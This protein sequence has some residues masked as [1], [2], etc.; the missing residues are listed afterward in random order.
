MELAEV[1]ELAAY[2]FIRA[3]SSVLYANGS[4]RVGLN[5]GISLNL[6]RKAVRAFETN[7]ATMVTSAIE[8]GPNFGT[9]PVEPG[10]PVF[11]HS[12]LIADCRALPGFTK[13]VE[14]GSAIKP[15]HPREF[16]ECEGFRFISSPIF[17]PFLAAGAAYSGTGMLSAGSANCDVYPVIIMAEGAWGHVSLKGY[18]Y[19]GIKP[20]IISSQDINHANPTGSFGYVGANFWYGGVRLN[21]NHMLRI[22]CCASDLA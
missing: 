14:Y 10:Y 8:A 6:L 13:R 9:A 20:T 12:H 7:R 19:S 16:G 21:E 15:I 17:A 2:G 3:G 1:A 11:V 4:T 5:T 22:E 18:N